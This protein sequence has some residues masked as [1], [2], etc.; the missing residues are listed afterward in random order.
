MKK[1]GFLDRAVALLE[2]AGMKTIIIDGVEPNP[3][4]E[5]VWAWC[6]GHAGIRAGLDR[7]DWWWFGAGCGKGY[8]VFL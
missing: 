3:S 5:T 7:S 6:E 1:F 2:K 8:V 4:V